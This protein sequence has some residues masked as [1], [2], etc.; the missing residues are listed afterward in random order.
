M[1]TAVSVIIASVLL[2]GL[3]SCSDTA[4]SPAGDVA[5]AVADGGT[6][7]MARRLGGITAAFDPTAHPYANNLRVQHFR[8]QLEHLL[9][10][11]PSDW[12][13]KQAIA[14]V[15]LGL[16]NEL[17]LDGQTEAAIEAFGKLFYET[18]SRR[19]RHRLQGLLGLAHLRLGEQDNCIVNHTI[20]SCLFPIAGEGV[21]SMQRGSRAAVSH[22]EAVLAR[23]PDDLAA[24]W[25]LNIA[26]MTLGE[27]PGGVPAGQLLGPELFASDYDIGRF[28]DVAPALG[29]DVVGLSGGAVME[30]FDRDGHLDIMASSWGL[31]DQL[32]YFRNRGDGTFADLTDA[33]GLTGV[34]GGLNAK[35]ADYDNDGYRDLL[36]LRGAW[37]NRPPATDGGRH[38]NSLLKNHGGSHFDDVTEPAGLLTY[39]P[40]QTAAW[41]DYDNDGWLD[42]FVGN[43]SFGDRRHACELFRN[44]GDGTFEDVAA[45]TGM[46]IEG[47]VKAVVW[48]DYDNDG[49]LDLYVSRLNPEETNLLFHNEG[50]T[51]PAGSGFSDVTTAAGV[52]GPPRSFP[53]WF[54]D[55][56]DDGWLDIFVSGYEAGAGDVAADYLGLETS[57]QR[58]RLYRNRGDGTFADV[59]RAA[60]IDKVLLTMG[61]NYG[62]LDNDGYPDCYLGTGDPGLTSIMPNRMFRNAGGEY[63]QDVTSSGGFGHL[64]K[65][66]GVAFGDLDHDGDQEVFAVM[67][68]AFTG[69]VYQNVLFENP[70]HGN[71][72]L[73]L[74]LEGVQSNRD[75]IGARVRLQVRA[76]DGERTIHARVSGGS[77]FGASSF[78]REI[79]L[80]SATG[81][82]VLEIFWPASGTRQRFE[83]VEADQL[84]RIRE[85]DRSYAAQRYP[86]FRLGG[87]HPKT[88]HLDHDR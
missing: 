74:E 72:W 29:L 64:Q 75:A 68:G 31:L 41:G 62:D 49:R 30:D 9:A 76:E 18:K 60:R 15:R 65:G 6:A 38:P 36:I 57:A 24:R 80:G 54:W 10:V 77:S 43:E 17:L 16:A 88:S 87:V 34:T 59:T 84:L 32:R 3:T 45:A 13:S 81:V 47:Y 73:K 33:A 26:Y 4:D 19:Q 42:L 55:Y 61:S 58:P 40:T 1:Q 53:G 56:D 69:D 14:A 85:G 23:N 50:A 48:G 21:H 70:G 22:F 39:H 83:N 2:T 63:F 27:Y 82:E 11:G 78:R 35:Q 12:S 51:G 44:R 79:G 25:M 28:R 37:L 71:H 67:G 86:A 52:P 66:H 20:E 5:E 46:A 8:D 7:R